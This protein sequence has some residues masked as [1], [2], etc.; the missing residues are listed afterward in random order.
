MSVLKYG[1][2]GRLQEGRPLLGMFMGIPSPA[3]VEMVGHARFDFVVIDNE[4]GPAGIETTEH[5]IR[6]ATVS[7][8]VPVVRVSGAIQQEILRSL[9]L[10]P[11]GIQVPQVNTVE[12][13]HLLVQAARYPPQGN[14]GVAFSTRA[15]GFGFF[16]GSA[17]IETSNSETVVIAHIETT[18]AL[19]HLVE[20]LQVPGID[21]WFVGPTDLS[22]SMGYPGD[23]KHPAVQAAITD[24]MK[25]IGEAGRVPG[26][27]VTTPEDFH[28]FAELGARYITV[29]VAAVIA[30]AFR[31]VASGTKGVLG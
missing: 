11:A 3:L 18:Q 6:A 27:M 26:L 2:A 16:G 23:T 10:G 31:S 14:R 25:Q 4:H 29:N 9:D 22:V 28:A 20:L 30:G 5:L 21:V 8:V 17:H 13:A 7:G 19:D 1:L 12:Q 15:A 24:C